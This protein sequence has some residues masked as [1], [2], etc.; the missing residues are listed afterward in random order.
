M[1]ER[2]TETQVLI[3]GGGITGT[4]LVRELSKYKV[5]VCLV[6]KEPAVGF[7]ISKGTQ[8]VLHGGLSLFSSRLVKWFDRS[9][10]VATYIKTPLHLK[11]KFNIIGRPIFLELESKLNVKIK[12][13]GIIQFAYDKAEMRAFEIIKEKAEELGFT[14][15]VLLDRNQI[16]DLEPGIDVSKRVGGIYDPNDYVIVVPEWCMAFADN[17][18]QNGAHVL[19]N[20]EVT[21]IEEKK[22]YWLVKTNNGPI[23]AEFVINAAGVHSDEIAAMVEKIDWSYVLFDHTFFVLEN[24]GYLKHMIFEMPIPFE[25]CLMIPTPD[26]NILGGVTMY[27]HKIEEKNDFLTTRQGLEHIIKIPESFIPDVPWRK[28]IMRS[29]RAYLM[30]NTRDMDDMLLYWP[31]ER[32]LNMITCAPGIAPSAG[33]AL[34]VVKM[35]RDKGL[36]L[37][38]KSDFN[39]YREDPRGFIDLPTEIKNAKIKANPAYGHIV[40]RCE[41]GTEQE[42]RNAV[43]AGART[44]DEVKFRVRTGMGRCQGGFCTSRVLQIMSEEMGVSPLEI[45][46]KGGNSYILKQETK[47]LRAKGEVV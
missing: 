46:L 29:F 19:V 26:G 47:E 11:E 33:L 20:T 37:V 25:P 34:E 41:K 7:G 16:R 12:K 23:K 15:I 9:I 32:F 30:F 40:C 4:A 5:D 36:D 22:G 45:K 28:A 44:L 10:D 31:R 2:V 18:K 43:R 8:G 27:Q 38:E 24:K 13:T 39:P 3:I 1:E 6:E 21:G 14:D 35:L 17:A 42:V